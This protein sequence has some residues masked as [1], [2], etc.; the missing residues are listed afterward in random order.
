M[1]Q[2]PTLSEQAIINMKQT[3]KII[4]LIAI[5]FISSF[6]CSALSSQETEKAAVEDMPAHH[7][8]D[9][10]QNDPFV[11]SAAS[12]GVFFYLRRFWG[13]V[14]TP[15]APDDHRLPESEAIHLLNSTEGDKITWL[16]H[17]S[18]LI[19]VSDKTILT[20]PFLSEFASPVS[21]AGPRRFVDPGISLDNLPPID[22]IVVSHNHYDHLD[23][24]TISRL[25]NKEQIHVVVPLGLKSFF[26]ERG[27]RKVMELDWGESVSIGN[28]EMVSLPAVHD[29]ARST[30]DRDRTLWSSWAIL[31]SDNRVLFV[32]DTGYSDTLFKD[33]GQ[34][35][36]VFD[37]A[38]LPIGAY[39]PRELMWMSHI[40][41]E[42]A[43]AVG[44]EVRAKNIIASHWGTVSSLSDEPTWEPPERFRKAGVNGGYSEESV[45]I[46]KIGETRALSL[47]HL[48]L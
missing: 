36:G 17:A 47:E 48:P 19:N 12:K 16:G 1:T 44:R 20:D 40:T 15:N 24:E 31:S 22:I 18:F 14:F 32:G 42:E 41:P 26:V 11:E 46:M 35:Y 29:S 5:L 10:F 37:Y 4:T 25:K 33:I 28:V 23:D 9:G 30:N 7:T 45:W 39:E 21:W 34:Q 2:W 38:I 8:V 43:V 3:I 13:S 6:A 27:Y